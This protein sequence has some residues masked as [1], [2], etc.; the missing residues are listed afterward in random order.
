VI[1]RQYLP[2]DTKAI[3]MWLTN[4]KPNEWHFNGHASHSNSA[5]IS[6]AA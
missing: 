1:R 4:R 3:N 5:D 6:S 2:P